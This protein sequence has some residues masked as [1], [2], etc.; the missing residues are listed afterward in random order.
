MSTYLH[1]RIKICLYFIRG[2]MKKTIL[3]IIYALTAC[4]FLSTAVHATS[5]TQNTQKQKTTITTKVA[6]KKANHKFYEKG[7]ATYYS[8]EMH[9]RK[10]A[11]GERLNNN[12]LLAAHKTLPFGTY[13]RVTALWNNK[14]V[15]V[16]IID[17]GPYPKGR[18]IDL[19]IAAAA[20]IGLI[21][22]GIGPVKLEV[23]KQGKTTKNTKKTQKTKKKSG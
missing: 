16:R 14:Q 23:V 17:R 12:E 1:D 9:G 19:S 20:Q 21:G 5:T 3:Q 2:V 13:V 15:V 7:I 22:K 10:T 8:R 11:S 18:V 4:L 6:K